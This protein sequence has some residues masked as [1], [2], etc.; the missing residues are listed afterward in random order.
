MSH[1]LS[2]IF[3]NYLDIFQNK[4]SIELTC[5]ICKEGTLSLSIT[6]LVSLLE[7]DSNHLLKLYF[8]CVEH[9]IPANRFCEQ[10]NKFICHFCIQEHNG[11]KMN[12]EFSMTY[13]ND[14]FSFRAVS[15]ETVNYSLIY[16]N[17]IQI[18]YQL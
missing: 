9:S 15:T 11:H 5:Q 1:V 6:Q 3:H 14:N 18:N 7:Q 2:L 17:L 8:F 10:C 4:D 12:K 16:C 13:K